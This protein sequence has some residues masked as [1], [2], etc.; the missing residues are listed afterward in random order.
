MGEACNFSKTIKWSILAAA[1]LCT[2]DLTCWRPYPFW[3]GDV[4]RLIIRAFA[5]SA[6][7][8]RGPRTFWRPYYVKARILNLVTLTYRFGAQLHFGAPMQQ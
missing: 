4:V 1:P 5:Y 8:Y 2:Y 7:M 3:R 6:K